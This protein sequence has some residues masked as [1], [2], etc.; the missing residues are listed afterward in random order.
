MADTGGVRV[1]QILTSC[2][3]YPSS[4][5]NADLTFLILGSQL[6]TISYQF[7]YRVPVPM[8]LCPLPDFIVLSSSWVCCEWLGHG[9]ENQLKR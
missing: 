4:L 6:P 5:N 9:V 2:C 8:V 3:A 1:P 7:R